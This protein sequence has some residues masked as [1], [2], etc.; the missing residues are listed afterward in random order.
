MLDARYW[1]LDDCLFYPALSSIVHV[2]S[3]IEPSMLLY[4]VRHAY[5]YEHGDPRWPDDSQRPLEAEGAERF[6]HGMKALAKRGVDPKVIATSPYVRC[7]QTAEILAEE[8]AAPLPVEL[9][10][11]APG[12]DLDELIRWTV[13]Q[14]SDS[15]AWVGHSPDVEFLVASLISEGDANVRFAKGAVA[16]ICIHG[17]LAPGSGELQWLATLKSLGM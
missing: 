11:L 1:L 12:S 2:A 7:R 13:K 16:A 6:R 3:S 14:R 17:D 15:A 8:V 10:A 5:A 9:P 4:I